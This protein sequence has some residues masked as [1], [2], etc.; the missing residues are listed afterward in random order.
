MHG[1]QSRN[2]AGHPARGFSLIELMIVVA[3]IGILAGIAYPNYQEYILRSSRVAAQ[4]EL[5]ELSGLQEKIYLNSNAFS[6]SV[7]T[8]YN[9]TA[10]G[11][12]G[13]TTG[14]SQDSKYAF[15]VSPNVSG[16]TYTLTATPVDASTLASIGAF[17]ISSIGARTCD[18]TK[19]WCSSGRW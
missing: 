13:R 12:L 16:Q 5:T 7:T 10:A 17:S 8:A 19:A 14:L 2:A 1:Y 9:G 15:T 18:N 4:G 11:G 3:V 6:A